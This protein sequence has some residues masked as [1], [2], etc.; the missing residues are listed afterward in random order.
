MV[1]DVIIIGSG[2]AG[3]VAAIKAGQ[4]GLKTLVVDQKYIGGMCLNWGCIPTKSILESAKLLRKAKSLGSMGIDGI[5]PDKVSYNWNSV[6]DRTDGIVKRLSKGIEYLWKKN[7]V[8]FVK[9][10]ARIIAQDRV[11]ADNQIFE[12]RHILIATGSK[13][14][15]VDLF[16]KE[17]LIELEAFYAQPDLPEKPVI[18]GSGALAVEMAQ[19]FKMIGKSPVLLVDPYPLLTQNDAYLNKQLEKIIKKEKIPMLLLEETKISNKKLI[20]K[21]QEHEY[22]KVIN[23]S[24][25]VATLPETIGLELENGF[26]RVNEYF[27][28]S[29][30]N[31]YAVGDVNGLSFLAHS[32]SAQG[33]AAINH[34]NGVAQTTDLTMHPLNIYTEPELAHIGK[35]EEQLQA[36][37]IDYKISEYSFSA[38]G[39]ALIEGKT[40]GSIRLLHE[41]RYNQVLGV[42]IVGSDATDLISEASILMELEG[43]IYDV[44]RAVH[45]HPTISEVFMEAGNAGLP[46]LE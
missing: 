30:P 35:T 43:T 26:F 16:A 29:V 6:K 19:Y 7:A 10:R 21:E 32:A 12:A 14:R 46:G 4:T 17:D 44:A 22:D 15:Q 40:E 28:T 20:H 27:Q 24:L 5:D 31:I 39:K 23:C 38:N 42:Q 11:E 2:P 25:R 13:P 1:Y 3:Y 37:G 33:L 45:A 18:F 36:E 9:G 8:D 34:I 41:T